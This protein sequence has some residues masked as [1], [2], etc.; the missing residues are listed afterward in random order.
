M[1]KN[2]PQIR[3]QLQSKNINSLGYHGGFLGTFNSL[4][5]ATN[6][7][8]YCLSIALILNHELRQLIIICNAILIDY[9]EE[10]RFVRNN[11]ISE[12]RSYNMTKIIELSKPTNND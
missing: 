1:V 10:E 8:I 3:Q 6:S 5:V 9:Q 7:I 11:C 12:T 2:F 4:D